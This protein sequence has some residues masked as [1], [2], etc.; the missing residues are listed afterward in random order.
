MLL[1][2]LAAVAENDDYDDDGMDDSNDY[3]GV[4]KLFVLQNT[5]ITIDSSG[6]F[7]A[8]VVEVVI[9]IIVIVI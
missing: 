2:I 7:V 6:A 8:L 3:D 5:S 9:I 4:Y 1:H